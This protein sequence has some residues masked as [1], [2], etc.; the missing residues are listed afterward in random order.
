MELQTNSM[1]PLTLIGS[2]HSYY[3][4]KA[5]AYLKWSGLPFVQRIASMDVFMQTILPKVGWAVV[6]VLADDN[7]AGDIVY[8]QDTSDIIDYCEYTYTS[9]IANHALPPPHCPMQRLTC[10]CLELMG[11]EWLLPAAMHYRW[12]FPE[13]LNFLTYEW[14]RMFAPNTKAEDLKALN[15]QMADN[16]Q[17]FSGTLPILGVTPETIP[18]IEE[19]YLEFLD[20]FDE[21]LKY[22]AF[23]LGDRPCLADFALMGPLYA[24]LYRDPVPGS[25]MKQRAPRVAEWV[26]RCNRQTSNVRVQGGALLPGDGI[27]DTLWPILALWHREHAPILVS[28]AKLLAESLSGKLEPIELPRV[29]DFH[30]FKVGSAQGQRAA[31]SFNVWKMQRLLDEASKSSAD[32]VGAFFARLTDGVGSPLMSMNAASFQV[33]RRRGQKSKQGNNL[34]SGSGAGIEPA[35]VGGASNIGRQASKL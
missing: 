14:G 13:N 8:V 25:M 33:H 35:W 15:E 20:L 32:Q 23:V 16:M 1:K 22:H 6:P 10:F 11:D 18:G 9:M 7:G 12:S 17:L 24:H 29:V 31:F 27:P 5:R 34:F 4:G 28:T 2:E 3:T 26:D 21:H 30:D 19:T